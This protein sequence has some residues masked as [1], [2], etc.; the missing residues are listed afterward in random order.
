MS[1]VFDPSKLEDRSQEE[2]EKE[3]RW[4]RAARDLA[5]QVCQILGNLDENRATFSSP[6]ED[7]CLQALQVFNPKR[8]KEFVVDSG[9]LSK[10]DL[11]AAELDTVRVSQRPTTVVT[12]NGSVETNEEATVNFKDLHL[13]VTVQPWS[14][15]RR[16]WVFL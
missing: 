3:Q 9:A 8:E 5:K 2:I 4:A 16:S 11:N 12:V 15:L 10:R 13:F 7:W 6:S 14:T 1:A